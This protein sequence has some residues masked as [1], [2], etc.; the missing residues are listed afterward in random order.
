MRLAG[1]HDLERVL[2]WPGNGLQPGKPKA[3]PR[4]FT[5]NLR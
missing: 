3:G 4:N 1:A 2:N 5:V